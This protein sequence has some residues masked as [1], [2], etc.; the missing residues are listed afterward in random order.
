MYARQA[1]IEV[2]PMD[3]WP[4]VRSSYV[5]CQEDRTLRPGW[6]RRAA[7]ERLGVVAIEL[8]AGHCPHVSRPG[9]LADVLAALAPMDSN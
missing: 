1:L 8:P 9:E 6:W 7:R 3:H 5:L 2:C 4:D